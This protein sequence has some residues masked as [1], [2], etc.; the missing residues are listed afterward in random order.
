MS[1]SEQIELYIVNPDVVVREEDGDGALLFNPDN[2][3]VKVINSTGLCIWK[4][5]TKASNIENII[6]AVK[7]EFDET[8]EEEILSDAKVFLDALIESEFIG[9]A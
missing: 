6:K 5:C 3:D 4:T 2:N 7:A 1:E 9:R 8:P